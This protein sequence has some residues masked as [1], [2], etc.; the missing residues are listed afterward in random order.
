MN[1]QLRLLK[2]LVGVLLCVAI[3]QTYDNY[4]QWST[5][6]EMAEHIVQ[7]H[8]AIDDRLKALED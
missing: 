7:T 4:E 8:T 5:I 2:V 6:E 1:N 3:L